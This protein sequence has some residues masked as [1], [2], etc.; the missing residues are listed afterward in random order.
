MIGTDGCSAQALDPTDSCTIELSF[1]PLFQGA[2]SALIEIRPTTPTRIRS[3][4][5]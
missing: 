5:C 4:S 1:S 3:L 2:K